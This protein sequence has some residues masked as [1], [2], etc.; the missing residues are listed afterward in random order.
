MRKRFIHVFKGCLKVKWEENPMT[1]PNYHIL[2]KT[3]PSSGTVEKWTEGPSHSK[4][5]GER[6]FE[7]TRT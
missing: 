4:R 5:K 1:A 2:E 7:K 3:L 6:C